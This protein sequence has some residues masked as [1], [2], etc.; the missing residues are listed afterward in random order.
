MLTF[1]Y[2]AMGSSKTANALIANFQY[3]QSNKKVWLIKPEL[4]SRDF[5]NGKF[6]IKSRIGLSAEAE[7]IKATDD[8]LIK[9]ITQS[10]LPDIIIC[11]EAQFLTPEQVDALKTLS[12]N[13]DVL[14]YGLRTDFAT[15]TFPGSKRLLE[16][17]D[18]LIEINTV[19]SCGKK[20]TVNA[21]FDSNGKII[22]DGEQIVIGG[23]ETYKAICWSCYNML[24]IRDE[25]K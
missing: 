6:V 1:Y 19:C 25:V 23:D 21:R 15:K 20:A 24:R 11:D 7:A 18:S 12:E 4:D 22:A 16:L 10:S 14:C 17:A 13:L 3:N 8:I 2:G 5:E 9:Y